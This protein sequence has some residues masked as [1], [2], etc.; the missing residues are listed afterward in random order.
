MTPAF[1]TAWHAYTTRP[2]EASRIA[3]VLVSAIPVDALGQADGRSLW[4]AA[5]YLV[6]SIWEQT[7]EEARADALTLLAAAT[8]RPS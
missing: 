3:G 6:Q 2:K 4:A 7:P 5:C 8:E 1:L